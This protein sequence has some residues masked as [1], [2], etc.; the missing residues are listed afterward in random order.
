MKEMIG[1]KRWLHTNLLIFRMFLMF[2]DI[3]CMLFNAP[4][5]R[6]HNKV[7]TVHECV[8]YEIGNSMVIGFAS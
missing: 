8:K 3:A 6:N 5:S 7:Y 2:S 4:F 1:T